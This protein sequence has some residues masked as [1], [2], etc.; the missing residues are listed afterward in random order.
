MDL[1]LVS[2]IAI[3]L[4]TVIWLFFATIQDI[5]KR[6]VAN[7]LS[8]S[9]IIIALGIRAIA[10]IISSKPYYFLFGIGMTA[11][12]FGVA[13]ILYYSRVF[14]GGDAKLLTA[15]AAAFGTSPVFINRQM[16][17][18]YYLIPFKI[19]FLATFMVNT[20]FVGS[21][22]GLA[23]SIALSIRHFTKFKKEFFI[24]VNQNKKKGVV[25]II[26]GIGVLAL[27]STLL[28]N[29]ISIR[30]FTIL[31]LV[32]P[33]LFAYVKAVENA[34]MIAV[35]QPSKLT[36]GDWIVEPVKIGKKTIEPRFDGLTIN[37]IEMIKKAKK[38]VVI[39]NGIPFVP[40]F[41]ISLILSLFVDVLRFILIMFT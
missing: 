2:D 20:L 17:S 14:A 7:W 28:Y 35:V 39:K 8:F 13:N 29:E 19:P 41:F 37:E 5:K 4:I 16:D 22:Y 30:I 33:F 15:L 25:F 11:I 34:C 31:L 6:E 40:V 3:S 24:V 10:S 38:N 12:F 36:E 27:N 21:V 18:L 23:F 9:L 1:I 26:A 32:F